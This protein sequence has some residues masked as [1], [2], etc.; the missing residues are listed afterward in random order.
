M[1]FPY[2]WA[3]SIVEIQILRV[4]QFVILAVPG[5]LTTMSGRR[6]VAAVRDVV[7]DSWGPEVHIVI[8]GLSNTYSSYVTT[9]EEYQVQR[10][11]GGFTLFGP[12][13]LD[14]YIQEFRSLAKSMI[15]GSESLPGPQPPNLLPKQWSLVP[16]VVA[17]GVPYGKQFGTPSKDIEQDNFYPGDHVTVEFHSA[18]P[19]NDIRAEDTFLTVERLVE[20]SRHESNWWCVRACAA[21]GRWLG[22]STSIHGGQGDGD[23]WEIVHTD[24]DWETKFSW[25]RHMTFSTYSFASI[26]W[27]IPEDT[28]RGTYRIRHFGNYKH[29]LGKG[30]PFEGSSREF[31]VHLSDQKA[32]VRGGLWANILLR[33]VGRRI[34]M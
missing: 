29:F 10:Y 33:I 13:T 27:D 9:W 24:N 4:G 30:I 2:D 28:K 31:E 22:L 32:S 5:E 11:E 17:D 26:S 21:V 20:S 15:E 16:G 12:H 6:L 14:A 8:A 1:H 7:E 23:E 18:C 34:W 25:V 3:P 19:R